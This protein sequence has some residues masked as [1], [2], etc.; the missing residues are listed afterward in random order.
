[1]SNHDTRELIA[2]VSEILFDRW[3]PIGASDD[4]TW[5]RDEYEGYAAAVL[6]LVLHH[7]SDDVVAEHLAR[8]EDHWMGLTP[9]LLARRL[10]VAAEL[11]TA[12]RTMREQN[13]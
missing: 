12:V 2:L 1:V 13:G 4:P 5:P 10:A 11:R 7:A 3:D 6:G 9:S 8:I